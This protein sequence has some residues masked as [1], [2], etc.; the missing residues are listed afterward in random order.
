MITPKFVNPE[1]IRPGDLLTFDHNSHWLKKQI[2]RV[3]TVA[4]NLVF[5][6]FFSGGQW[7]NE[8]IGIDL[9]VV[10]FWRVNPSTSPDKKD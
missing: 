9:N 1:N 10:K 6:Q 5:V 3:R 7:N 4:G 2:V 8:S